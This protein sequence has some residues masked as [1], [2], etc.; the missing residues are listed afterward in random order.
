[1]NTKVNRSNLFETLAKFIHFNVLLAAIKTWHI[2]DTYKYFLRYKS[3]K[4]CICSRKEKV[5]IRTYIS[6]INDYLHTFSHKVIRCHKVEIILTYRN[7][8]SNNVVYNS[9]IT[10]CLGCRTTLLFPDRE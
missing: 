7:C 9:A 1:M 3:Q 6:K 5:A 8:F 10:I 4:K 2:R